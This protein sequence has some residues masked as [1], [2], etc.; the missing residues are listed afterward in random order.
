MIEVARAV[1]MKA[2]VLLDEAVSLP[3]AE[4]AHSAALRKMTSGF[5]PVNNFQPGAMVDGSRYAP[6][7]YAGCSE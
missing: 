3:V 4:R 7:I 5:M 1:D 6:P 2:S